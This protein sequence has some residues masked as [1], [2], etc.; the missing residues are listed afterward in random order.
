MTQHVSRLN[1]RSGAPPRN[2]V[3]LGQLLKLGM[4][5]SFLGACAQSPPKMPEAEPRHAD[6]APAPPEQELPYHLAPP[7]DYGNKVVMATGLESSG[8][9]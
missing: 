5:V 1:R 3:L 8:S 2:T 9:L 6:T 7:P 4:L